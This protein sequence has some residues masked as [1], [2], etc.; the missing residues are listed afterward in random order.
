MNI[1]TALPR[2]HT[3]HTLVWITLAALAMRFLCGAVWISPGAL[4]LPML[5]AAL[6]CAGALRRGAGGK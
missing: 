3:A 6:F 1:R 5:A 4:A 2:R